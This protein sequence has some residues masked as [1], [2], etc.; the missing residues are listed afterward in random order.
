[1]AG[2]TEKAVASLLAWLGASVSSLK[3]VTQI[4][5]R[6]VTFVTEHTGRLS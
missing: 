6:L 3:L 2:G 4:I 1:M 5:I